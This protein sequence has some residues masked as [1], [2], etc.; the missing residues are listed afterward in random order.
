MLLSLGNAVD[1]QIPSKLFE[2][3][4]AGKPILHLSVSDGDAALPYL[5]RYPLALVLR[6]ADGATPEVV[7][8]LRAWLHRSAGKSLSYAQAAAIFPEFTPEAVARRF[9]QVAS[10]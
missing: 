3:F 5:K 4:G 8:G 9:V 2:Y 10:R 6:A 7:A 1:N